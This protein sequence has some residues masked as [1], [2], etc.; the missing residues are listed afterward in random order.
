MIATKQ[1]RMCGA[2]KTIE[3]FYLAANGRIDIRCIECAKSASRRNRDRNKDYYLQ[4]DR[5][6]ANDTQRVSARK[7]YALSEHGRA[8]LRENKKKWAL[9]N[10]GKR[11]A[12]VSVGNAI[13]DGRLVRK[14]C[15]ICGNKDVDAHHDDYSQPLNVRWFCRSCHANH[16]KKL[17]GLVVSNA[18]KRGSTRY[19][20]IF[21]FSPCVA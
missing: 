4:Y 15:E 6:R 19:A 17:R 14:E 12:H 7:E 1:C 20:D 16:H 9:K 13:R 3:D 21:T 5:A 8:V 11:D 2:V 18:L 10:K